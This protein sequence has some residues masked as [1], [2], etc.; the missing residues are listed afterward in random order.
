MQATAYPRDDCE[1]AHALMAVLRHRYESSTGR[2]VVRGESPQP[3]GRGAAPRA[4]GTLLD[5]R[6]ARV[7]VAAEAVDADATRA[8]IEGACERASTLAQ[9]SRAL[10]GDSDGR[11]EVP[12][13]WICAPAIARPELAVTHALPDVRWVSYDVAPAPVVALVDAPQARGAALGVLVEHARELDRLLARRD[14]I[15]KRHDSVV[16]STERS[17][18]PFRFTARGHQET[19]RASARLA[20]RY[21][22]IRD[23]LQGK[24]RKP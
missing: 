15:T 9:Y 12:E 23:D 24:R 20:E 8:S 6:T 11:H 2:R 10:L 5:V 14:E 21:L 3:M 18:T 16:T 7:W 4:S 19:M 1:L 13:I 22:A 17:S